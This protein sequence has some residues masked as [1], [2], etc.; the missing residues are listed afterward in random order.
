MELVLVVV[1]LVVAILMALVQSWRWHSAHWYSE[2]EE[3]GGMRVKAIGIIPKAQPEPGGGMKAL[4]RIEVRPPRVAEL[5][6]LVTL[7]TLSLFGSPGTVK[8]PRL[9]S[10]RT[11]LGLSSTNAGDAAAGSPGWLMVPWN[12]SEE[13][14]SILVE[15]TF[16]RW[17]DEKVGTLTETKSLRVRVN[18]LPDWVD[19]VAVPESDIPG[20]YPT[21]V[22][23][24]T[25][26]ASF[27]KPT[28]AVTGTFYGGSQVALYDV[29]VAPCQP[30]VSRIEVSAGKAIPLTFLGAVDNPTI[31]F[32]DIFSGY[33][34][35]TTSTYFVKVVV[36]YADGTAPWTQTFSLQATANQNPVPV[37]IPA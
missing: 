23:L 17:G 21:P 20:S 16:L 7:E 29:T 11:Q 6:S 32:E 35:N 10:E 33:Y 13:T 24:S 18:L 34:D 14:Y 3:P 26:P 1:V 2:G 4:L 30:Q 28:I 27:V 12:P 25:R 31:P 19:G 8:A 9:R 37:P 5:D 36:R 22:P 15:G